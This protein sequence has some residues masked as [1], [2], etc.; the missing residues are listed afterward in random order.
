MA[1]S[2]YKEWNL[3][4]RF[5]SNMSKSPEEA[6]VSAFVDKSARGD[7][8]A[9][10]K[11]Y[12]IY[13]ERIYKYVYYHTGEAMVAEDLTQDIFI[14][15]WGAINRFEWKGQ[16]F[17]SW[18]FRIAHNCTVDYYRS[19]QRDSM[20]KEQMAINSIESES[21]RA[22][23]NPVQELEQKLTH[24]ELLE[25]IAHLSPAQK[26]V[27]ILKFLEGMENDEIAR[28]TGK[29][30]G[31]IRITQMRALTS[32]REIMSRDKDT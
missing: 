11:L 6:D 17:S 27:I 23:A 3:K 10:G 4:K 16:P 18:L 30:E 8:E 1:F 29:K 13:M 28:I 2:R 32:L 25:S 20:L 22:A 15:A 12:D 5:K 7:A 31:A 19:A 14:K 26:E 9:F 24:Q 21:G